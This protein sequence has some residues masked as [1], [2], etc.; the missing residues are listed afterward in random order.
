MPE[1]AMS[2]EDAVLAANQEFYRAF[3]ARDLAAMD[4][5]WAT[6][7][8]RLH[9]S[10]L[11]RAGRARGGDG[12]LGRDPRRSRARRRSAAR[13]RGPSSSARAPS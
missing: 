10:G 6:E 7:A 11:G 13:R 2:E 9:P 4:A 8:G 3:A 5:L 12:E 1:Q